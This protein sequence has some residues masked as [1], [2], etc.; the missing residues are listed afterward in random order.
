MP[1]DLDATDKQILHL[2]QEDA[3]NYTNSKIAEEVGLSPSTAGKRINRLEESGVIKG[4]DPNIDYN[5]AGFPLRVLFICNTSII[6]RG[7][8]LT[9]LLKTN[10]VVK[11][12]E[13]M[14]GEN[15][16]HIE[17]VGQTNDDITELAF[18]ISELGIEINEEILIKSEHSRPASVFH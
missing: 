18:A 14:T 11:A 4:Y 8:L 6:E 16:I 3:R 12:T 15:N 10:G 13:L 7:E 2:L 1:E 9:E 5:V 17:V